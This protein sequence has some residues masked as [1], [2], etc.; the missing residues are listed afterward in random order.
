MK[1]NVN[2]NMRR[3]ILI[4]VLTC[5]L[6]LGMLGGCARGTGGTAETGSASEG[7]DTLVVIGVMRTESLDPA[8]GPLM[9]Q[10][11]SHAIFDT[12]VALGPD[13]EIIPM[14]AESWTEAADGMSMDFKLREDV[15]FHNG[16]ALSAD[17]V[18]FTFETLLANPTMAA[19][20]QY[21]TAYEKVDDYTVRIHRA[22]PYTKLLEIVALYSPVMPKGYYSADPAAFAAAPVG[23]GAYRFVSKESDDSIKLEAFDGYYGD[24]PA[25]RLAVIKAP[26]EPASSVIALETGEADLVTFLPAAQALVVSANS[27]LTLVTEEDAWSNMMV[28][29]MGEPL[30]SDENLRKAIFHGISRENAITLGNEGNGTVSTDL[31]ASRIMGDSAGAVTFTGY[32]EALA[33]DY[34][35]KS[36]YQGEEITLTIYANPSLA[37]SIQSDLAQIGISVTIEQLDVNA[38]TTKL[39]GGE[40][41]LTF[42]ETGTLMLSSADA[43]LPFTQALPPFG[44]NM[45]PN[46]GFDALMAQVM[47]TTDA[48]A[49]KG[50]VEEAMQV[51]IDTGNVIPLYNMG[52]SYAYGPA[53][54]Y[55]YPI[56]SAANIYYLAKVK[57]A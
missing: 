23:T 45:A 26:L 32:D 15:S 27:A 54:S 35:S 33:K 13:G 9:D 55:D 21:I 42:A 51:M 49:R 10:S 53:V 28:I 3:K 5:V 57:S 37:V 30:K 47:T 18:V 4:A 7:K 25:F 41:Q 12:L 39:L 43:L 2:K 38:Y 8:A 17:D 20:A 1:E 29:Q 44:P 16:D 22:A 14:L 52:M 24:K 36:G 48:S 11:V 46:A 6:A 31:F 56:S 50:L 19:L 34:L 40:M